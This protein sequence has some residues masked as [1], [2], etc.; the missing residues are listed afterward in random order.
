MHYWLCILSSSPD[1]ATKC[2]A[3]L[4]VCVNNRLCCLLF[5]SVKN[6]A[7]CLWMNQ[8]GRILFVDKVWADSSWKHHRLMFYTHCQYIQLSVLRAEPPLHI[9]CLKLVLR[10]AFGDW[11]KRE[12]FFTLHKTFSVAK[13]TKQKQHKLKLDP[14]S[15]TAIKTEWKTA[16]GPSKIS[17]HS[18]SSVLTFS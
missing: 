8:M 4:I 15:K 18:F 17:L 7:Y 5:V 13:K 9:W 6:K 3:G 14:T 12:S 16:R 2:S 1:G 10:R 11:R